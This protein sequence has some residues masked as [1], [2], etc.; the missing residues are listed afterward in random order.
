MVRAASV[1]QLAAATAYAE[2]KRAHNNT[3]QACE[4]AGFGFEPIVFETTGGLDPEAERVL[5]SVLKESAR[6]QGKPVSTVVEHAKI[7]VSIDIQRAV[8]RALQRRREKE[9]AIDGGRQSVANKVL[10]AAELE[11]PPTD[12]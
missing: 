12:D 4:Q 9:Q 8:H 6:A 2:R 1:T 5:H 11:P 10:V 7:R 3:Q